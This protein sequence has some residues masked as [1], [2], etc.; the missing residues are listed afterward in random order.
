LAEGAGFAD[1]VGRML[2]VVVGTTGLAP[3][4]IAGG[5]LGA[6][7]ATATALALALALPAP[8][9]AAT[10]VA[11]GSALGIGASALADGDGAELAACTSPDA[12]IAAPSGPAGCLLV[13]PIAKTAA[14]P[15]PKTATTAAIMTV[16]RPLVFRGSTSAWPELKLASITVWT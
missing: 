8:G 7:V 11:D 16:A 6:V 10:E 14:V 5:F 2:G 13:A 1:A 12:T 4:M 15:T 9:A 3:A